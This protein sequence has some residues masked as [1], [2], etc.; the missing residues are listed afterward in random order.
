MKIAVCAKYVPVVS[1]IGF[2]Y[3][4]KTIIREGVP[5]EVNPFDALGIVRAAELKTASADEVVVVSMGPPQ[6]K[7][8]LI[9][10]L[11]LGADRAVLLTDR[12]L[13]G[14]DTLATARALA[15]I[16]EREKPELIICGRNSTDAETGQ[17]GPEIAELLGLPHISQVRQLNYAAGSNR[18]V[19]E[20]ITDDGYQVV[21]CPLP[22]LVCVTEGV[23]RDRYPSRD[24]LEAAQNVPVE[25]ISAA[26]LS[27]DL[28]QFGLD[29][30][31]TWVDEIRLVEPNRLGVVIRDTE[32]EEAAQQVAALL[33]ERLATLNA[34]AVDVNAEV[35]ATRYPDRRDQ[36]IWVVAELARGG[37][38]QVTREL[39]GKARHLTATTQSEVVAVLIGPADNSLIHELTAYG[40]DRVLLL[41]N[42]DLG[43]AWGRAVSQSL[44]H[45]MQEAQPYAV[46]FA[47]TADG[48][49][50]AARIAARLGLGLTGDAIDLEINAQG[51]LVQLKPALGGNVMAPI[52]SKTLPN[53]VTLRPGVLR[54]IAPDSSITSTV[55]ESLSASVLSGPDVTLRETHHEDN[56]DAIA[57]TQAQVVM[58]IGMGFGGPDHLAD[59]QAF[60]QTMGATL[61]TTRNVV[62]SGWLPHHIQVGISGRTIAPRVYLAV[63]IRGAFNHTVGI[64]KAGVILALNRN[65]RAAIFKAADY[66]IV[67]DWQTYLPPLVDALKPVVASLKT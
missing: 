54:P 45:A 20:R 65:H 57:L 18:I 8:G 55:V 29:G 35:G 60:A 33:Q 37:L 23:A 9:H 5:S 12:A 66:G 22:A 15:F 41:D 13:A 3:E 26:Q 31:P 11:A 63:G 6:A 30:S 38:R 59:M 28:S 51:Q 56:A 32:P 14:S 25:E 4:A 47:S 36:S 2:D 21:E 52:L 17:V 42:A 46:L 16:L 40:A 67:G 61:A 53:L 48:R 24:E 64:Q 10:S 62:H 27:S 44:A 43:P 7:E 58:G 1:Q 39:L 19:V 34:E 49:D 50:I